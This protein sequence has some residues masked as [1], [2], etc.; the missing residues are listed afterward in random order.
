MDLKLIC[1]RLHVHE[2][3]QRCSSDRLRIRVLTSRQYCPLLYEYG[4]KGITLACVTFY[5]I[6]RDESCLQSLW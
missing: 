3:C 2:L 1:K 4:F 6:Q 5:K